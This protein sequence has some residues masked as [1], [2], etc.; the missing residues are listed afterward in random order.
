M[1]KLIVLSLDESERTIYDKI[2][3]IVG[4]AD[5]YEDKTLLREQKPMRIG[6][7]CIQPNQHK[8]LKRDQ[9]V[10]L[11]NIEFRILYVLALHQGSI[12]S[13]EQ[14]YNFVWNGLTE[15]TTKGDKVFYFIVDKDKA[16]ENVYLLTEV[17]ENDLLNFTDGDTVTLPQN[18]AVVEN[19]LP[20]DTVE[21]TEKEEETE[22]K[23]KETDLEKEPEKESSNKGT[24]LLMG[25]VLAAVG[26]GY[27][28]MKFVR[29]KNNTF[30]SEYEE[31]D[32]EEEMESEMAESDETS[33]ED[34]TE[35]DYDEEDEPYDEEDYN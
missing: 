21:Q 20:I 13:K 27:Y 28:Y 1:G 24:L 26:G 7:L 4:E 22:D 10:R 18:Q 5:I 32:D 23:T 19:A 6:E 31:E 2:M 25:L 11:T 15:L 35:N 12:L 14:I 30:D 17:G 16:V 34:N 3:K 8:V 9:E 29:G 33:W